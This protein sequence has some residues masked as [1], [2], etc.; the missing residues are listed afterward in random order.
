[1]QKHQAFM[2]S[3]P[4]KLQANELVIDAVNGQKDAVESLVKIWYK[5]IYNFTFKYFN[6]HDLASEIAQKSFISMYRNIG[7]LKNPET[8]KSWLYRIASNHCHEESRRQKRAKVLS[9]H[10]FW[11]PD[12]EDQLVERGV[13]EYDPQ[14]SFGEKQLSELLLEMLNLLP[15]EQRVIVIMK[16]YEGFRFREIAEILDIS[17]N[18]AKSR[19]Y[20]GLSGLRKAFEKRNLKL[21][22]LLS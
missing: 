4:G 14:K 7:S 1:M 15:A 22:N 10:S 20:Y 6:D 13:S 2:I 3:N 9:F 12:E 16:E 5:R 11:R 18:T 8:F 21:E 17:E 19:L